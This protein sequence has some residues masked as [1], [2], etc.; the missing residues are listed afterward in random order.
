MSRTTVG[1][2]LVFFASLALGGQAATIRAADAPTPASLRAQI[3]ALKVSKVAWRE[4]AWKN[5]LLDGLKE[6]RATNKPALLW[7]FIDR[8]IDDARC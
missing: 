7:V 6:S 5:C 2:G 1:L 3:D 8:P 4:I